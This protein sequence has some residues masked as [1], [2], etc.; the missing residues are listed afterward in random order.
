MTAR[1]LYIETM[2]SVLKNTNKV[3]IDKRRLDLGRAALS[4]AAG[5]AAT[6]AAR[7]VRRRQSMKP[8]DIDA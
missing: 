7:P 4:A 5:G 2:E 6:P 8:L 1:R 3:M